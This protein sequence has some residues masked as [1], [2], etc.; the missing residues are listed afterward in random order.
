LLIYKQYD[1]AALDSQY[2]NRL[3]VPDYATYLERWELLS[4]QTEEEY[5]V[6]KN[7]AYGKLPRERLDIYPSSQPGSKTLIFIHGGYWQKLDKDLFHFIARS[8]LSYRVTTVLIGYPLAPAASIDRIVTSCRDAVY[9]L[10][11]HIASFNGDPDQLYLAG[12]S[13]GGHL[14][15]MLVTTGWNGLYPDIPADLIKGTCAISGLFNLA[16]LRLADLNTVLKM[17]D[18]TVSR[19]S[20]VQLKPATACPLLLAAGEAESEEFKEQ[21]GELYACWKEQVPVQYLELPGCNHYSVLEA[22]AD[23]TS[24]LYQAMR[25]IMKI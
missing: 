11:H 18:E 3:R 22:F 6:I 12:H 17:D 13:A 16:P 21:T 8:F 10:Y 24:S 4:R 25:E 1:Q 5:K 20:P 19:N 9:W 23:T 7:L 15:A 14:A 2:N